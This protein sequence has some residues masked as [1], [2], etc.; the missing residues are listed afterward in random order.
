MAHSQRGSREYVSQISA[1]L[2]DRIET[3]TK[4]NSVRRD[5]GGI[6]INVEGQGDIWYDKVIMAAHADESL[7]LMADASESET[8]ILKAFRFQKT[9]SFFIQMTV[10]C[11]NGSGRGLHGIICLMTRKIYVQH[12]G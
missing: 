5:A 4:V 1:R 10:S 11:Q 7:K 6:V 3:K 9:V 8:Q 2:N 12:I